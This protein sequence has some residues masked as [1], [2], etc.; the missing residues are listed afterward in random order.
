M[1]IQ[2]SK[3]GR[4]WLKSYDKHV[5]ES[6]EGKYFT[7]D[8]GTILTNAM[9]KYSDRV[10][11]YFMDSAFT[12]GE[13]LDYARR[14]ATFLQQNGVKKGDVVAINLPNCPQYLFSVYGTYI[15]GA[16]CSGL[17]PLLSE[18]E[19][20][21]QLNDSDAKVVVT[22]DIIHEKRFSKI[23]SKLPNLEILIPTNISE[24]MGFGGFKV[25][26]GKLIKKIPKGKMVP[27]P[28]KT[29]V[30]FLEVMETPVDVKPVSIDAKKDLC[31]LQYTGGTTGR[32]KGTEITH[33]NL[34]SNML[35]FDVWL[36]REK[37]TDIVISA[38]PY[39]HIAGF[40]IG[41]YLTYIGASHIIIANP[42][43]TDHIINEMLDKKPTVFG[44][45]PTL[46]LM[47]QRNP[48]S[49]EIPDE[50][51]D[52]ITLYVSG[53]APFPA[54]AIRDF[55]KQ[56]HTENKFVEVY[57][58]TESAVLA[59]VNPALGEKKIGTVGLPL[60]DTDVKLVNVETGEEVP[61][62][63]PGEIYL[64]GPQ[65][66]KRYLK[67]PEETAETYV[68]GWLHT[69]DVGV[70]DEDGYLKIV[71]RTKDMLSIS[72]YK[73]YSVHVEDVLTK[74]PDIQLMA[75]IGLPDPNRPGSEIVKAVIQLKEGIEATDEVKEK[76]LKY[77]QE[78]LAKYEVPKK[79]EFV[80]ELPTT[81][82]GKVLK[83]ALR[84]EE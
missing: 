68:D 22:M 84:K 73:V 36:N 21:Y 83:R 52:N 55:E 39:F 2:M 60:P 53:A 11:F 48:K 80:E 63:E 31:L 14:F 43:D 12:Y 38:F 24:Y 19:M 58:M 17:S 26:M 74:H 82:I 78:N 18:A 64:R 41:I 65:I 67:K 72:G 3:H 32:P 46:F 61:I 28:G 15:A 20:Q 13:I 42:R 47:V 81:A 70:F 69:G 35:Q 54:E 34:A 56:F 23:I 71:D 66:T 9:E 76:I 7:E 57:G 75:I 79:W 37:G 10:G 40:F 6:L 44:N 33:S 25:F 50:I 27:Y 30:P 45:V 8:L 49:K 59:T 16:V 5:P 4:F 77:A 29:V 51:L 62:G 1:V